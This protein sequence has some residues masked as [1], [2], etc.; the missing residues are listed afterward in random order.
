MSTY[1]G[2]V[3]HGFPITVCSTG[4]SEGGGS[5][6]PFRRT[7]TVRYINFMLLFEVAYRKK[8]RTFLKKNS[9]V[10][11]GI[12]ETLAVQQNSLKKTVPPCF[13]QSI[14]HDRHI[15]QWVQ[16][17]DRTYGRL[18]GYA[19]FR[20]GPNDPHYLNFLMSKMNQSLGSPELIPSATLTI[21]QLSRSLKLDH[22]V[23]E[24]LLVPAAPP[25]VLDPELFDL[26]THGTSSQAL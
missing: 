18:I 17:L 14:Y 24:S 22:N 3:V 7:N 6:I 1:Q 4:I 10:I 21:L 20:S 25:R 23:A 2:P 9:N 15:K 16:R 26:Q 12:K 13:S 8:C 19:H 11:S 5:K